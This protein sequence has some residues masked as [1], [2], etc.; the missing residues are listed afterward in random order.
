MLGLA[1]G[2]CAVVGVS[3]EA[4]GVV[5]SGDRIVFDAAVNGP[6]APV[7]THGALVQQV[8]A[9]DNIT[10]INFN[11]VANTLEATNWTVD[12]ESDWYLVQAGDILSTATI[13][14]NQFPVIFTADDP[15][16]PVAIPLG[17]F[18]LGVTTGLVVW[19]EPFSL[20]R[21]VF[22]WIELNNT[23]TDLL[24]VSNAVAYEEGGI[25]VGTTT[26]VPEVGTVGLMVGGIALLAGRRR[27]RGE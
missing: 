6:P 20:K 13:A 3:G 24:P 16:P 12:E 26:A 9:G 19:P 17:N 18:Y 10:G 27:R 1:L 8:P 23:G 7:S 4:F 25:I 14:A 5:V 15:R 2:F 22:G 21:D 11:Y